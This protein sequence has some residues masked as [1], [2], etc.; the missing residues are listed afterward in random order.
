MARKKM[1]IIKDRPED[2]IVVSVKRMLEKDYDSVAAQ[3]DS[4]LSEAISQ[5]YNKAKEI[6]TGRSSQEEMRRMGVYP[7]AEAFKILKEKACP[8]SLRAFTG[9]VGRGSI[10]SIKIG[11][12]RYLTKHVVDQLTG[13][14]TDYY[15][16]KDSYNIL[17]KYRPIDFRAFIGRIEK[18]S[19]PSIKIGT[20]RLIP[21]DYVE[22]MTHVYQTYMEVRDSLAYLSGQGVKINKNA[23]ERR[24]DRERIPHAKIAGKRYIDRGVLDELASQELARMNLNRQ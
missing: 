11:G 22:L 1:F 15:S 20:K 5:V 13:M 7:L 14:Y 2:T 23:F 24:L 9:R 10:K 16:V 19:V 12:R 18:N 17:N 6:Y 4:K 8:L 3:Q 21:R